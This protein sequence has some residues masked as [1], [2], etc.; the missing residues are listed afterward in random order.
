ML[1]LLERKQDLEPPLDFIPVSIPVEEAIGLFE[2]IVPEGGLSILVSVI[3]QGLSLL[4]QWGRV[5]DVLDHFD[6]LGLLNRR[7]RGFYHLNMF[8]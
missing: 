6:Y 3:D 1:K 8:C 5:V 7:L 4:G 2:T